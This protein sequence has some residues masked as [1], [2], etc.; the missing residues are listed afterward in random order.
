MYRM[1]VKAFN[2][3]LSA[4]KRTARR[5]SFKISSSFT[6]GANKEINNADRLRE[7]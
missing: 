6:Y 4:F 2:F 5:R 3:I 1:R 7:T